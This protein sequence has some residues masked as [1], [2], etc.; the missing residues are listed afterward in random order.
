MIQYSKIQNVWQ[1]EF[2]F[3]KIR[4]ISDPVYY[5]SKSGTGFLESWIRIR[6]Q[7]RSISTRTHDFMTWS[8]N[9]YTLIFDRKKAFFLYVFFFIVTKGITVPCNFVITSTC[10]LKK[11]V[12]STHHLHIKIKIANFSYFLAD[13]G[14]SKEYYQ[15]SEMLL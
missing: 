10:N 12:Q 2:Y 8:Y 3:F 15:I 5:T 11:W 14:F 9:D 6:I 13:F 7:A 1:S 4:S